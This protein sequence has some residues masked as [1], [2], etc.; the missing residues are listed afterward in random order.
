M[1]GVQHRNLSWIFWLVL[2][3]AAQRF[4]VAGL[5]QMPNGPYLPT[6]R[7]WRLACPCLPP[8]LTS[9]RV[10]F[11]QKFIQ[12]C[13]ATSNT[14]H[15]GSSCHLSSIGVSNLLRRDWGQ[16]L[17]LCPPHCHRPTLTPAHQGSL[18]LEPASGH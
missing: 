18:D 13:P 2:P 14:D 15:Q 16:F 4:Q 7:A 6:P 11:D 17:R 10:I 12:S 3:F 9:D 8:A 1:L 5:K